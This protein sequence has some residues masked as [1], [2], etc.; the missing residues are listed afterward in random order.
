MTSRSRSNIASINVYRLVR[1]LPLCGLAV[2][3]TGCASL[4]G[5]GEQTMS[6]DE[7]R[8]LAR[9]L[10]S[11]EAPSSIPLA[12]F[13]VRTITFYSSAV[14]NFCSGNQS[15]AGTDIETLVLDV[16]SM[17]ATGE[18]QRVGECNPEPTR[19][20]EVW[21]NKYNVYVLPISP[22][23]VQTAIYHYTYK[24]A[25]K[26]YYLKPYKKWHYFKS[27]LGGMEL[28][29]SEWEDDSYSSSHSGR[30]EG[31]FYAEWADPRPRHASRISHTTEQLR[32]LVG[33]MKDAEARDRRAA[34]EA[35]SSYNMGADIVG[36]INAN[37]ASLNRINQAAT[38]NFGT[39]SPASP[40]PSSNPPQ[41]QATPSSGPS[42]TAAASPAPS[43]RTEPTPATASNWSTPASA[44]PRTRRWI[45]EDWSIGTR[46]TTDAEACAAAEKQYSSNTWAKPLGFQKLISRGGCVCEQA[47]DFG[48]IKTHS[49]CK[50]SLKMEV[51]TS[52]YSGSGPGSGP[53]SNSRR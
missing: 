11:Q 43:G 18:I 52:D 2:V 14:S 20:V 17:P 32:E 7:A 5:L 13:Y 38:A 4:D 8:K 12:P 3:L 31:P 28:S 44:A 51:E 6:T 21:H 37:A 24:N 35:R 49:S 39:G 15:S 25:G 50:I 45:R 23:N 27:L 30:N 47:K 34:Q 42:Q 41:R 33:N 16:R 22:D 9:H 46:G 40:S 19:R 10:A 36:H 1:I 53:S 48:T 29:G 26:T